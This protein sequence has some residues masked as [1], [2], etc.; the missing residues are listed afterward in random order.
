MSLRVLTKE[1]EDRLFEADPLFWVQMQLQLTGPWDPCPIRPFREV[2]T[3]RIVW[4]RGV[5]D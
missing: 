4:A 1:E 3:G 2:E 5:E